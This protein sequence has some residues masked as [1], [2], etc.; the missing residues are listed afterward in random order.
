MYIFKDIH[1]YIFKGILNNP[2]LEYQ[3]DE[4][5]IGSNPDCLQNMMHSSVPTNK[6]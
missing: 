1:K 5:A 2:C 6:K 3:I 4:L